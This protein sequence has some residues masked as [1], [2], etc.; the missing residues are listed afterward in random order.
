MLT[1][2]QSTYAFREDEGMV[3]VCVNVSV[4]MDAVPQQFNVTFSDDP[5]DQTAMFGTG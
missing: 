3:S 5:M 4:G 1:P 2:A